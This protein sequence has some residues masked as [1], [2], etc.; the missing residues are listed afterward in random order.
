[1]A[2]ALPP[3]P[4]LERRARRIAFLDE[5][6]EPALDRRWFAFE[7][8]WAPG[9]RL[10]TA[11][12]GEG[13]E[14]FVWFGP[15]GALVRGRHAGKAAVPA[16]RLFAGLPPRFAAPRDEPA[17]Q[18]GGDSFAAWCGATPAARWAFAV[19]P[20]KGGM[21]SLLG[22]LD[23]KPGSYAKHLRV[24][25]G[26]SID[27]AALAAFLAG[28]AVSADA[29]RRLAPGTPLDDERLAYGLSLAAELALPVAGVAAQSPRKGAARAA[30][31]TARRLPPG[32]LAHGEKVLVP[33]GTG[34][35]GDAEYRVVRDGDDVLLL[36]NGKVQL[37]ATAPGLYVETIEAVRRVLRGASAPGPKSRRGS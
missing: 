15:A 9:Q 14:A 33:D 10:F 24:T 28:E 6:R 19:D 4:E 25:E 22:C 35:L 2:L 29:L 32:A 7:P 31:K 11:R 26:R 13:D 23:G 16:T 34:R 5:W 21:G 17:F 37:T 12:S 20:V 8:A 36:V 3:A 18:I 1:M 27:A 30:P